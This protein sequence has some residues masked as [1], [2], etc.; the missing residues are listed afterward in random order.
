MYIPFIYMDIL[1]VNV[2]KEILPYQILH[3]NT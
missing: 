1:Q 3:N 2:N